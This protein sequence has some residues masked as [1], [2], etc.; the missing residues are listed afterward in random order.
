AGSRAEK[1]RLLADLFARLTPLEAKYVAKNLI[2]EM[3]TGAAEGVLL[4]ALALV[5][6]G[7]PAAVARAHMLEGDLGEVAAPAP[8]HR[9]GPLPASALAY[10]RP[11]RPILAQTAESVGEVLPAIG[12]RAGGW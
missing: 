12:V 8:A 9:R 11:R 5:A 10:L 6:G 2:R 1:E 4:D 7:D 3:R